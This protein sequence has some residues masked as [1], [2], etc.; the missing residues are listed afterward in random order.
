LK[1]VVSLLDVMP[2]A[3]ALSG[4]VQSRQ[5]PIEELYR[6]IYWKAWQAL[7]D[8][9]R[10]L[11]LAM[12]LVA[13]TGARP[14]QLQEITGLLDAQFWLAIQ[15]LRKRSLLEVRGNLRERRYGIHRLTE[16]FLH[17]E[18]LQEPDEI[19]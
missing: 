4:L 17:T 2:L 14:E 13:R 8:G 18:I 12:P 19:E 15:E 7:S 3:E 6:H 9:A 11:L 5:G 16:T 1:L 10:N